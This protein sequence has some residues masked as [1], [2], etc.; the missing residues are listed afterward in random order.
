MEYVCPLCLYVCTNVVA[1]GATGCET[2]WSDGIDA[3]IGVAF[4]VVS[5]ARGPRQA[6]SE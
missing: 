2:N 6:S 3:F 1:D 5:T 4:H